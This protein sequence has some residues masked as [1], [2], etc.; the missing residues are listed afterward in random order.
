MVTKITDA[1]DCD[2]AASRIGAPI[3]RPRARSA[4]RPPA[5]VPTTAPTQDDGADDTAGSAH[6]E[7]RVALVEGGRPEPESARRTG[8]D[9][10]SDHQGPQ[11][12]NAQRDLHLLPQGSRARA[13]RDLE[14]GA[15]ICC[16]LVALSPARL[17]HA[18]HPEGEDRAGH[19]D[20]EER[21]AP[22]ERSADRRAQ[23]EPDGGADRRCGALVG[24]RAPADRRRVVVGH[25]RRRGGVV[26]RLAH[27]EGSA[28]EE[29]L[30]EV[31]DGG[32][33]R[34]D[35]TPRTEDDGDDARPTQSIGHV[36]GRDRRQEA[37]HDEDR[38]EDADAGIAETEV[39]LDEGDDPVEDA[40]VYRV[41]ERNERK[42]DDRPA[43]I[44]PPVGL[45]S[46]ANLGG[47]RHRR[48]TP[49]LRA[50]IDHA[51]AVRLG[52][53]RASA[54]ARQLTRELHAGVRIHASSSS[55]VMGS[56]IS[57]PCA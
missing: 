36:A 14:Q 26:D 35:D 20:D 41:D 52:V 24:V 43:P 48:R 21:G 5:I 56:E 53:T 3:S 46:P 10:R 6:G 47:L 54:E 16:P 55:A 39:V 18:P 45:R 13:A 1:M 2:I 32:V 27:A 19:A 8:R 57:G 51:S 38:S 37:H 30:P 50:T 31:P 4:A 44:A 12:G 49:S 25:Q 7:A 40:S 9:R 23:R 33:E 22:A 28:H 17:A 34:G 42:D 29:E 11:R 15:F